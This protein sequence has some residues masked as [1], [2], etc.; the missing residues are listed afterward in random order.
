MASH[1]RSQ[2]CRCCGGGAAAAAKENRTEGRR[3]YVAIVF[4]SVPQHEKKKGTEELLK[5]DKDK[6]LEDVEFFRVNSMLTNYSR[7]KRHGEI[8]ASMRLG[9]RYDRF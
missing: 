9:K 2:G 5:S 1:G 3:A 4:A 7:T 6:V 8:V